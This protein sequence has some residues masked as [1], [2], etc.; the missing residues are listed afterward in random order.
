MTE[1]VSIPSAPPT[2]SHILGEITWLLSQSPLHRGL[3]IGDLEWLVMPAILTRQFY[4]FRDGE[5]PV[6]VALWATCSPEAA[7]KLEAGVLDAQNR[8]LLGDWTSGDELWLIDLVAPFANAENKQREIMIADLISAPLKGRALRFHRTD[9]Q[10]GERAVQVIEADA[11]DR[12]RDA[13]EQAA[14][15]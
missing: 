12:L 11:G 1:T 8:L 15:A 5:Q 9:P 6:G 2:V 14:K 13:M 7:K 4:V 3:A 10:T